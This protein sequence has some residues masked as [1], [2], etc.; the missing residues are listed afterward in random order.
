MLL[1]SWRLIDTGISNAGYNMAVDEALLYNFKETDI[2]ILR[3]Y[4]WEQ[5]LSLG[6]FSDIEKTLNI[7]IIEKNNLPY[8]R[9]M[10][11]GGIL[12]HGGDLSY[13]LIMHRDTLKDIGVKESYRYLCKFLIELYKR[14]GLDAKFAHHLNIESSKSNICMASNEPYDI[15]VNGKKMGGNAQ[16]YTSSA[17]F[18]HG[19]IPIH[20]DDT[21]FK[22]I[23]LE[24]S[25]LKEMATLDKIEQKVTDKHITELLIESFTKSFYVKLFKDSMNKAELKSADEFLTHKYSQKR[26]NIDA[27]QDKS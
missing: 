4:R 16:R 13:S 3:L 27:R 19:S 21:V 20:I 24:E 10:S 15:I 22:D 6:R 11:G 23:F 26:W 2:P 17:L 12:V 7:D 18:Q 5:S 14:L 25:G 9:R 8:V 1:K